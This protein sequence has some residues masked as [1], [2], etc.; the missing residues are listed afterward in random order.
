MVLRVPATLRAGT[1]GISTSERRAAHES[2]RCHRRPCGALCGSAGA[3]GREGARA[4]AGG[5]RRGGF[6]RCKG[7]VMSYWDSG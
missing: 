4:S 3:G 2:L 5:L 6:G 7:G 1:Q